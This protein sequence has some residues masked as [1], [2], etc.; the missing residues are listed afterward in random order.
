MVLGRVNGVSPIVGSGDH[1]VINPRF[2]GTWFGLVTV[3]VRWAQKPADHIPAYL[4][5]LFGAHGWACDSKAARQDVAGY[6]F[7]TTRA[8]GYES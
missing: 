6:G 8:C 1:T 4:E 5:P 2:L 7:V 3:V